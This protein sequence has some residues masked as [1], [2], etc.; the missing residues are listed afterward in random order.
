MTGTR[1]PTPRREVGN[2]EIRVAMTNKDNRG[3][4]KT[5]TNK[6]GKMINKQ[7]LDTCGLY[8]LWRALQYHQDG[9]GQKFTTSLYRF[10]DWECKKEL[11]KKQA[12]RTISLDAEY[13]SGQSKKKWRLDVED[14][15]IVPEQEAK[16]LRE[17]LKLLPKNESQLVD[18]YYFMEMTLEQIGR[19]F[20]YTKEAARQKLNKAVQK[21]RKVYTK[22]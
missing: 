1:I 4:I 20:G 5:V 6:Y 3:I 2:E 18:M 15:S 11:K 10:V 9:R 12:K 8:G 7:D 13:Q 16:H 19:N 21:L 22:E 17:C 14:R